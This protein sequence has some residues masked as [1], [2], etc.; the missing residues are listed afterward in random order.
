MGA[1]NGRLAA[2]LMLTVGCQ[3][4]AEQ[5]TPPP[6]QS[7]RTT[8]STIPDS[9]HERTR[10]RCRADLVSETERLGRELAYACG[11]LASPIP[12][13]L[14]ILDSGSAD[15]FYAAQIWS[16]AGSTLCACSGGSC[17][18]EQQIAALD[19][20]K[21]AYLTDVPKIESDGAQQ[22]LDRFE[23]HQCMSAS[24]ALKIHKAGYRCGFAVG[25][26]DPQV[27]DQRIKFFRKI[28]ENEESAERQALACNDR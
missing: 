3:R 7:F 13:A 14:S 18:E 1:M 24:A 5:Y 28:A 12:I 2:L 22:I 10:R 9:G 8:S 16:N 6:A 20:A 27:K 25:L 26:D 21:R 11:T 17:S 4:M 19:L 15:G 23:S